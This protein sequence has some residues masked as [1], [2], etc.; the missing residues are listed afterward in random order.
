M[1]AIYFHSLQ[2][3]LLYP[4]PPVN[5]TTISSLKGFAN[6]RDLEL[7]HRFY[8]CVF[9]EFVAG[10]NSGGPWNHFDCSDDLR[11]FPTG[12]EL[13]LRFG[14]HYYLWFCQD[15]GINNFGPT[16]ADGDN[17]HLWIKRIEEKAQING[18][19]PGC[20]CTDNLPPSNKSSTVVTGFVWAP[21][22]YLYWKLISLEISPDDATTHVATWVRQRVDENLAKAKETSEE[23]AQVRWE[24]A[25]VDVNGDLGSRPDFDGDTEPFPHM[26]SSLIRLCPVLVKRWCECFNKLGGKEDTSFLRYA[27]AEAP[28]ND[29]E[30][31]EDKA[32]M[33]WVESGDAYS[34][35]EGDMQAMRKFLVRQKA[36]SSYLSAPRTPEP[37]FNSE[38]YA[39]LPVD[40]DSM[41]DL[42]LGEFQ[43]DE[44]EISDSHDVG[45]WI[46]SMSLCL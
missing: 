29:S 15:Q 10:L 40:N 38:S 46:I 42:N 30:T 18:G 8:Y 31:A 44:A 1:S 17:I 16:C 35:L 41:A 2:H 5:L 39:T 9:N 33:G 26:T 21:M 12:L 43:P 19:F 20:K 34:D 13:Y 3:P 7:L 4:P 11:N 45:A 36:Y 14:R 37:G 32:L 25:L 28:P 24:V 6:S 23:G 27:L 22:Y